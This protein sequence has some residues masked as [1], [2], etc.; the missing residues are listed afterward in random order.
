MEAGLRD[1]AT[2]HDGK[3]VGIVRRELSSCLT[4]HLRVRYFTA[5][6]SVVAIGVLP[7]VVAESSTETLA[8][9]MG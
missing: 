5:H 7:L 3:N 8:Q 2:G 6:T 9:A 4:R 1:I